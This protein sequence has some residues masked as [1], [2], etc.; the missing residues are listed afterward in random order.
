MTLEES[1]MLVDGKLVPASGGRTY[2][3][4]NPAT[5]KVIGVSADATTDDI[6]EAIAAARR[7]F[8]ETSWST[9]PAFRASAIRQ[10]AKA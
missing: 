1:R 5:E 4:I 6:K 9:D 10:L 7:A 8:D 2:D 3:N